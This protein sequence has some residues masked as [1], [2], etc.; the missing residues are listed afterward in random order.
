MHNAVFSETSK[1]ADQLID[2]DLDSSIKIG[3]GEIG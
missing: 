3:I 2:L 1:G